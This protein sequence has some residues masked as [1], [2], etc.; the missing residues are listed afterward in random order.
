[1]KKYT[2]EDL[3]ELAREFQAPSILIAA[4]ELDVFSAL[5]C[6][7]AGS[8][9]L[10][11]RI[12]SDPRATGILLDALASMGLLDKSG[13]LY[14]VPA[15]LAGMLTE[16]GDASILGIL[17]HQGNCMR[18]WGQLARVVLTGNCVRDQESVRGAA[19]DTASF[20]RAMHEI[21]GRIA[22]ALIDSLGPLQFSH[23][24]DIGG[25]SGTWTIPFLQRCPGAKATV[26][27]LPEVIPM[28]ADVIRA[29]GMEGRIRL[30]AGDYL[31][32]DLPGGADLAWVSAIVHQNSRE[33][34][35]KLFMKVFA[36]LVPGGTVLI[37]EVVVDESRTAPVMGAFFA[38]NMLVGTPYG[39]TFTFGELREDLA[40]AGFV[41]VRLLRKGEAMDSIVAATKAS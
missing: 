25:A 17:R 15:D 13:G 14:A 5:R 7:P 10:A 39:G 34:N 26:F 8:E 16:T 22:L 27:D 24:L 19:G 36:V 4:A 20:I 31:T 12:H 9:E 11:S 37:R 21:S 40:A 35:R 38:V 3:T 18:R 30:V 32:D 41:D 6:A 2:A 1:M 29:S 28:A 23:L 33:Q